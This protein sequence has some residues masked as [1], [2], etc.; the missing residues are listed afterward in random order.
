MIGGK[1]E[2]GTRFLIAA[3]LFF[4]AFAP[5]EARAL[6]Q[7]EASLFWMTPEGDV[8]VGHGG[9]SGTRVDVADDLG[10]D[11]PYLIPGG[12]VVVGDVHQFGVSVYRISLSESKRLERTIRFHDKVYPVSTV[13]DSSLDMTLV[14]AYYRFSPGTSLARGGFVAGVEYVAAEVDAEATHIGSAS[15]DVS[16]PMPFVGLYFSSYPLPFLGFEAS[17]CGAKW[18]LG[19]VS[20]TYVDLEVRAELELMLGTFVGAGYRCIGVDVEDDDL[21][22]KTDVTLAGPV[23]YLGLEW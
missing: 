4:W 12:E 19:D 6:L 2:A 5:D 3:L 1:A 18:D 16:S 11:G 13:V 17:A 9:V 22:V 23:V 8:A 7:A 15:G 14:K 10:Y 20:A 21:P